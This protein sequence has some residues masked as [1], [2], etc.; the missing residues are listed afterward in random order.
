MLRGSG[1][2][3]V[4]EEAGQGRG[5]QAESSR[6]KGSLYYDTQSGVYVFTVERAGFACEE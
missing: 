3:Q 1:E 2:W 4:G 6:S 5:R